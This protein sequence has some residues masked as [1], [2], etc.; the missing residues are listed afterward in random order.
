MDVF[1]DLQFG[2]DRLNAE[3][4]GTELLQTCLNSV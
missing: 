2:R 3:M 4:Q 1:L